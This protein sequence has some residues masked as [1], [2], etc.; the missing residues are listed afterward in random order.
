MS[1]REI[2]GEPAIRFQKLIITQKVQSVSLG[3]RGKIVP[4]FIR[5]LIKHF[6]LSKPYM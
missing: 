2:G 3:I 4:F 1:D 5:K 6:G